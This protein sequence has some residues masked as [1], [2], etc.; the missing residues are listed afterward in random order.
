M[1]NGGDIF[2]GG[3]EDRVVPPSQ[4]LAMAS[5]VRGKGL[6]VALVMFEGEGHGF[7]SMSARRAALESQVSFLEQVFGMAPSPDVPRLAIENLS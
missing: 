2:L 4:A 3:T 7:R 1:E 5:A 6:P